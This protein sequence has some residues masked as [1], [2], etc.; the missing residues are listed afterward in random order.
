MIPED[1]ESFFI[2]WKNRLPKKSLSLISLE[3]S[4][5][6]SLEVDEENM[7]IIKKYKNLGIIKFETGGV[8]DDNDEWKLYIIGYLLKV[9]PNGIFIFWF[10]GFG[11][12][13]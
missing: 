12:L 11:L 3:V 4:L 2:S 5:E 13:E 9:S 6:D 8:E 1:L 10:M 7:K